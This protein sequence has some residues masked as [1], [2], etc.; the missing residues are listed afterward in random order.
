L[1]WLLNTKTFRE[2]NATVHRWI[3]RQ[4]EGALTVYNHEK[5]G[6]I[7]EVIKTSTNFGF[8]SS[9]MEETQDLKVLRDALLNVLLAGRDTT[10]CMLTWTL[11]LLVTHPDVMANLRSEIVATIGNS[12]CPDQKDIKKMRYLTFVLNEG[13]HFFSSRFLSCR[14]SQIHISREFPDLVPLSTNS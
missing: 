9:L 6:L 8:L 11:R 13:K 12:R 4:I 3:D 5:H 14:R 7:D 1:Y 2:A 10:A